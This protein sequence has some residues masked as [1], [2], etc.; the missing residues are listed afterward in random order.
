M[1]IIE[2]FKQSEDYQRSNVCASCA[3]LLFSIA[4]AYV[5]ENIEILDK[6]GLY[7]HNLKHDAKELIKKFDVYDKSF[8]KMIIRGKENNIC[9]DYQEL[10]KHIKE[11]VE[12]LV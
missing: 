12:K 6:Y 3:Y 10:E 1:D 8:R 2:K 9:S 7:H 11:Y 4:E 5:E